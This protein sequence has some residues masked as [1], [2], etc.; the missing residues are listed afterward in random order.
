MNLPLTSDVLSSFCILHSDFCLFGQVPFPRGPGFYFNP[1]K[2]LAIAAVYL[3]W[4]RTTWWVDHDCKELELPTSRWN[5]IMLAAGIVGLLLVASVPVF[6]ASFVALLALFLAPTLMYVG[7]RNNL[8]SDEQKVLTPR[9]LKKVAKRLLGMRGKDTEEKKKFIPLRFVG[10]S[11]DGKDE[12]ASRVRRAQESPH[13]RAALQLVYDAVLARA[14]DIHLEPTKDEMTV[15]FRIDG[16][17]Q[18]TSPFGREVGDAV[19][20][21]FKVLSAMDIT[22]KRKPQDGSFSGEAQTQESGITLTRILDFRVATSGSVAG[23][24]MVIRILDRSRTINDLARLGMREKMREQIHA[25]VSQPHGMF[26]VCGPTGAGKSTTLYACMSQIDRFQKN[27]ITVENPVEYH[28]DHVTQIEINPKAGKTFATELRSILRQDPDVIYVGEIRDQETAEIA[29]QAAQTGHMVF[30]TLHA[31]DT[32]TAIIRLLD[33]GVQSYMV[34]SALSAILG[35]RLV[36]MLC[37][38]CKVAYRPNPDLLRR[39]N[40]PAGKIKAFYRPPKPEEMETEDDGTPKECPNCGGTG[41]RGRTGIFELLV[42]NDKIRE[43]IKDNPNLDVIRQEAQK[44]GMVYLQ[45]DGMRVV[46]EGETSI[47]ELLRVAK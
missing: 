24:K 30:T 9:H 38:N 35:Q 27:V 3:M 4:V 21:I 37:P 39:A 13:Y 23:E 22:E 19:L 46:I 16:I 40:L 42:V 11:F 15:R 34:A 20:N 36:R 44:Q 26:V 45:Q 47:E 32:P 31:N 17:L 43:M 10:K 18:A 5:P 8:V 28:I 33:L 7:I 41:Y 14:T 29:C 12:D 1:F 25:I 2:L 6:L